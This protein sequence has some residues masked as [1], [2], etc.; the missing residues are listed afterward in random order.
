VKKIL[1]I[2]GL[3][4]V[5]FSL[6]AR[7]SSAFAFV[8]GGQDPYFDPEDNKY[9]STYC[10]V[11]SNGKDITSKVGGGGCR[12][13]LG[14]QIE[15]C[16]EGQEVSAPAQWDSPDNGAA[17][18]CSMGKGDVAPIKVVAGGFSSQTNMEA[19]SVKVFCK[20]GN[21]GGLNTKNT[22]K[23]TVPLS[24]AMPLPPNTAGGTWAATF[25][26]GLSSE[27]TQAISTFENAERIFCSFY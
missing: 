18:T 22:A 3:L 14:Q 20:D 8:C 9:Y 6:A 2:F 26:T 10:T 24:A 19:A 13:V 15:N 12:T 23:Q 27:M 25:Q 4:F 7:T 17:I 11:G 5:F 21:C 1:F 16:R